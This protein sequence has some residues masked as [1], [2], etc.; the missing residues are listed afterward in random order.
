MATRTWLG[1][2]DTDF[3][4]ATNWSDNTVPV[5]TDSIIYNHQSTRDCTDGM[6]QNAKAFVTITMTAGFQYSLGASGAPFRPLSVADLYF[7]SAGPNCYF[8]NIVDTDAITRVHVDSPSASETALELQSSAI[9]DI[10]INRGKVI[11]NAASTFAANARLSIAEKQGQESKL[12]IP[13]GVTLPATSTIVVE[14]G[15]CKLSAAG[16]DVLQSGGK[17]VLDG[18]ATLTLLE[19]SG[20]IF[21]WDSNGTITTAQCKGGRFD[22]TRE[23][24]ARTLTSGFMYNDATVDFSMAFNLTVTNGIRVSGRNQ[25]KWPAG[26][27]INK[28]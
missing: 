6:D 3:D 4:V 18:S 19:L 26:T 10:T 2:T 17:F 28:V 27:A 20:G 23:D 25:P 14:G 24:V 16:N 12:T 15:M 7:S 8:G 1:T 5:T 22:V 11:I 13:S 9:S 21:Y